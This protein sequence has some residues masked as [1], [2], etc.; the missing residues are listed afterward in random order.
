MK[1]ILY[2][3]KVSIQQQLD[4]GI[5][6]PYLSEVKVVKD[7]SNMKVELAKSDSKMLFLVEDAVDTKLRMFIRNLK[8]SFPELPICLVSKPSLALY[9]WKMDLFHFDVPPL[10]ETKISKAITKFISSSKNRGKSLSFKTKDGLLRVLLN[11]IL[12]IKASGNYSEF[13]IQGDKKIIQSKQL[14]KFE[15][16]LCSQ[17][18]FERIHRSFIINLNNIKKIE[19][20]KIMFYKNETALA[21]NQNLLAKIKRKIL[22]HG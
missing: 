20:D 17:N 10:T 22:G 16:L 3:G 15:A 6:I 4:E 12:Y 13:Y 2:S 9:A 18:N 8:R 14:N 11:Q 21:V 19:G 1:V 5:K 7:F